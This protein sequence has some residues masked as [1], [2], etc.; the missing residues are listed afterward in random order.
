[1]PIAG[2]KKGG[3]ESIDKVCTA[4]DKIWGIIIVQM[5][6]RLLINAA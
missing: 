6:F 3:D 2:I 4:M 5:C 1:M